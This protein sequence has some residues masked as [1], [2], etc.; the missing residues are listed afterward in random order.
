MK[1]LEIRGL[2]K[3]YN[4]L[5]A[6]KGVNFSVNKGEFVALLGPNGAGKSTTINILCTLLRQTS[7]EVL[8]GNS[9]IGTDDDAIRKEIGIVFQDNVLDDNLTVEE[10]LLTRGILYIKNRKALKK[11]VSEIITTLQ[12]NDFANQRYGTLSGGQRRR[13][14]IAR[15]LLHSP[16]ILFLDE[17]TTGLDPSTRKLVWKTMKELREKGLTII[18]TTHY[19]EETIECDKVIIMNKGTIIC[20]DTPEQLRLKYSKDVLKVMGNLEGIK[21]HL[22]THTFKSLHDH[23]EIEVQ[24]SLEADKL[25]QVIKSEVTA[26]EVLRGNMD[27]VFLHLTGTRLN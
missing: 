2:T 13:T 25:L 22:S 20:Q 24:N 9:R 4:D 7:G 23:I 1:I 10:N 18:L 27:D 26:F 5:E 3:H 14:D 16:K 12:I 21:N 15:A 17:P 19:M 11:K 8:Y 6:V